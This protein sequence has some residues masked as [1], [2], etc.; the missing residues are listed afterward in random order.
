MFLFGFGRCPHRSFEYR[1]VRVGAQDDEE[2]ENP[3]Y[4]GA[5]CIRFQRI[6]P[7]CCGAVCVRAERTHQAPP[8]MFILSKMAEG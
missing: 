4:M 7:R 2:K 6:L 8:N 5:W 1:L 3:L